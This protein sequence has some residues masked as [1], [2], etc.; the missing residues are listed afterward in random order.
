MILGV[1]DIERV[2]LAGV[3]YTF[4]SIEGSGDRRPTIAGVPPFPGAGYT[5][6]AI[7]LDV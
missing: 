7:S 3:R 6:Q 2:I 1:H 4:W 5:L